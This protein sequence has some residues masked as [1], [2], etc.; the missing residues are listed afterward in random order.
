MI[1]SVF[2]VCDKKAEKY[3]PLQLVDSPAVF[4][5]ELDDYVRREPD[6]VLAQHPEDF[7]VFCVGS[8]DDETGKL[9]SFAAPQKMFDVAVLV[10]KSE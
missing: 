10:V 7:T 5:R 1:K 6:S 4:T 9:T 8:F 3:G 2:S